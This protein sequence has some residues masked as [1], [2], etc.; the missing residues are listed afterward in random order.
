V[1]TIVD[2]YGLYH[3]NMGSNA[4]GGITQSI[5]AD[6]Y[7]YAVKPNM[8]DKP[9][10]FVSWF[11][12]ARVANWYQNGAMISSNTED[13][14]Y[15]LVGG[16][17]TGTAP[18]RNNGATFYLPTEDQWYKAAYYKG[19]STTA[20]YWDYAT[21]SDTAPTAVTAGET[22]IGSAGSTGN[23][24]NYSDGAD[25]NGQNGNVTTVGTN[26]VSSAYDVFDMSGNI[27]EWNDLTGAA[28][29]TRGMRGGYWSS[30]SAFNLSSASSIS[31]NASDE[32]D[33]YGFRLASPASSP[34]SVPEID[35]NSIGSVLALVL[36]ALGLLERRRLKAA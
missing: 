5:V 4:R 29:S 1:A 7:F 20:G 19:G 11:D 17:T 32:N 24:A 28:G 33:N 23:F 6:D 8:G 10:N 34:S 14:A 9:V 36:G 26:G 18:A 16:Q 31:P 35:P 13:G 2:N 12:A 27:W 25:W 21:Q 3:P 15:T 22:G 30:F